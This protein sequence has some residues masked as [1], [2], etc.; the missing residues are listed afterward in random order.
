M[1]IEIMTSDDHADRRLTI[2]VD[3]V[4]EVCRI[5]SIWRNI[6]SLPTPVRDRR[7]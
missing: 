2:A 3:E 6:V 4:K 1:A 5:R 7:E